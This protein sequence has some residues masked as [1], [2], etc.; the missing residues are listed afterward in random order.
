[1]GT[2][3]T[4]LR[5]EALTMIAQ[6]FHPLCVAM[7]EA[8]K[9]ALNQGRENISRKKSLYRIQAEFQAPWEETFTRGIIRILIL[10]E[11]YTFGYRGTGPPAITLGHFGTNL[12]IS[13]EMRLMLDLDRHL[14][15]M[16]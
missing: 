6:N 3:L 12:R 10:I 4:E 13:A 16:K 1:M 2:L 8:G 9:A 7:G 5:G 11:P 14:T 15:R